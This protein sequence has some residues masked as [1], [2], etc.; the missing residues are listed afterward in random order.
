MST[1]YL[2]N[3]ALAPIVLGQLPDLEKVAGLL[4]R[5]SNCCPTFQP[6]FRSFSDQYQLHVKHKLVLQFLN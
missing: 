1:V 6:Q 5:A 2:T 3:P 4:R